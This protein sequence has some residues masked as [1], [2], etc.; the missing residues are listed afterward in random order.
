MAEKM[1]ESLSAI[2]DGEAN[3]VELQRVL[4]SIGEDAAL[5]RTWARY[6]AVRG[7]L[8]SQQQTG[9]E[10]DI[11]QRVRAAIADAP[12]NAQTL[13]TRRR[14][15][16]PLASFGLAASVAM[17]VVIGGQQLA[18]QGAG[19]VNVETTALAARPSPVGMLNSL[20]STP[21]QASYGTQPLPV[22]QPATSTA[23]EQLA[24]QRMSRHMQEHA[25]HAALNSPQGLIPYARVPEI[26]E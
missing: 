17:V 12:S 26:R 23:Y 7:V 4:S 15:W 22:L 16:R 25:E 19:E 24:R 20:G 5:R 11:S 10:P 18:Q 14:L 9:L 13:D 8:L 3:E 21:V 1:H 2:L 6:A